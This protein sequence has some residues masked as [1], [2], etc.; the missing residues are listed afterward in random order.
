[1]LQILSTSNETSTGPELV[2]NGDFSEL[3]SDLVQNGDFAEIGSE[4]IT[5]G[6]FS[7]VPL[8]S[9]LIT[10][11]DFAVSGTLTSASWTLGWNTP[12]S[13]LSISD[14][15]LNLVNDGSGFVGRV[16]VNNG[17]SS[18]RG[19]IQVGKKYSLTYEVKENTD[20]ATLYY[21]A[22]SYVSISKDVGVHTVEFTATTDLLIFRN[23]SSN[24]TI[25][26]DNVSVKEQINLVTNPNFTDTVDSALVNG[27][28]A[29]GL[30]TP[31]SAVA[32]G[33]GVVPVVEGSVGDYS[34]RIKN[35]ATGG[36]SQISQLSIF[37]VGKSYK[38][39]Y[40]ILESNDT[41]GLSLEGYQTLDTSVTASGVYHTIYVVGGSTQ[42]NF[43]RSGSN[44]DIVIADISVKELGE[45]WTS[46][47]GDI[48]TYNENGVTITS[49]NTD[50]YNRLLQSSVSED[51]K[52]YKVTYTIHATSFSVGTVVQYYDGIHY[53]SLPEQGIGTHT[54]YFTRIGTND[55]WYF[56]LNASSSG[57]TTDFVTISSIV[58]QELGEDWAMN[59]TGSVAY[60]ENGA[61]ITSI[62]GGADEYKLYQDDVTTSG[63]SYK[64]VY[65]IYANGIT[66]TNRLR[67][68]DGASYVV[69][70]SSVGTHTL[71]FTRVPT[72]D[73][74][75]WNLTT[76]AGTPVTDYITISS[77]SVKEV[78]QDWTVQEGW[79]VEDNKAVCD[80]LFNNYIGQFFSLP[81]GSIKVTFE[82]DSYTSGTLN[83]W[84][85][86]H[87]FTTII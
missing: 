6:D 22:G 70:D 72:V 83:L 77:T 1:M 21:Y 36:G 23:G 78:G 40:R 42:C 81:T 31:W 82:V 27:D 12:D 2:Q 68:Y 47:D 52:S 14:G 62:N 15:V 35:G 28:F 10:N 61:T 18:D 80:G 8:G 45:D 64:V 73:R 29:T 41:G 30:I 86:I 32:S 43:K 71:Y 55:G 46:A 85:N 39:E 19:I 56:N 67:Y 5:N 50:Q 49:I 57:S 44:I 84:A 33:D 37:E 20:A 16:Y 13:G 34:V 25:K 51:G 87:L 3:G 4:L 38:V 63:K 17:V 69:A 53:V 54:F 75:Y 48:D 65:T 66:G 11:G 7:A 24:T 9:E 59:E 79:T 76:D 60:N 58:V 26:I 74:W